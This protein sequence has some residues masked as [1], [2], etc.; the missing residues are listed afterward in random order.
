MNERPEEI[1]TMDFKPPNTGHPHHAQPH[2]VCCG[3]LQ[4]SEIHNIPGSELGIEHHFHLKKGPA[5]DVLPAPG[6][7]NLPCTL[8]SY[9]LFSAH[10]SLSGLDRPPNKTGTDYNGQSDCREN[11]WC[12]PAL[13][14]GL[15]HVQSQETKHHCRPTTPA[16]VPTSALW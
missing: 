11:H 1:T 4:V 7:L 8:Q 15:I 16:L 14:S 10:P 5:E 12:Q 6:K 9:S 3:N 2:C 13:H